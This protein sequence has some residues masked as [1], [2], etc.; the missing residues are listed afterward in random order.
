MQRAYHLHL[1][2]SSSSFFFILRALAASISSL[3]FFFLVETEHPPSSFFTF[4]REKGVITA[5]FVNSVHF[6]GVANFHSKNMF[7]QALLDSKPPEEE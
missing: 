3:V 7:K 5:N 4:E 1:C 6:A 2:F